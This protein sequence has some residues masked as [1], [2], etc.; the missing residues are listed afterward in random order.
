M[1]M[2]APLK[3]IVGRLGG[4][5]E[6]VTVEP[7]RP[8]RPPEPPPPSA[9]VEELPPLDVGLN[10]A[11]ANGHYN[12]KT[13]ELY[14]GFP[15]K[16]DDIVLDIGCG[17]GDKVHFCATRGAAII[18]SDANGEQV[19][20]A[21]RRLAGSRARSLLPVVSDSNPLPFAD[22]IATRV[23]ASEVIEHVDDPATFLSELVRV[24]QSGA[25]YLLSVPDPVAE[26]L[27]KKLAPPQYFQKPNHLRIVGREEF[28]QMVTDAGLEIHSRGSYGFYWAMWFLMFWA[29][30]VD[31]SE[32]NE[33]PVLQHWTSTWGAL[34]DTE[35]GIRVKKVF[36]EFMPKGQY[37]I[38]RKP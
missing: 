38:A 10:D 35:D 11:V 24:G 7:A 33:H 12:N 32:A 25:L 37:I 36:D 22:A 14:P 8:V 29:C 21:K 20:L 15:I 27:Q 23:I 19:A 13:G 34:L 30:K 5:R 16:P 3:T 26:N 6:T 18:F 9:P 4:A 28:G 1:S 31:L 17:N 2:L